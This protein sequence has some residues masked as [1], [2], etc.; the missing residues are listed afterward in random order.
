MQHVHILGIVSCVERDGVLDADFVH[1]SGC[2]SMHHDSRYHLQI[3]G[4]FFVGP[5]PILLL[6]FALVELL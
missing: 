6:S 2:T 1:L 4:P 3:G 5:G